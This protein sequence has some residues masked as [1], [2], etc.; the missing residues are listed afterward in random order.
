MDNL[1]WNEK[2]LS[3]GIKEMDA[4]HKKLISII[5]RLHAAKDKGEQHKV[6]S[7]ILEELEKYAEYH[8]KAEEDLLDETEFPELAPHIEHHK[9][10]V[11]KIKEYIER[12]DKGEIEITD[13]VL[14]FLWAWLIGHVRGVDRKY[15]EH[16]NKKGIR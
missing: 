11:Q 1:E 9:M 2:E 3:V 12:Y 14:G 15:T 7:H 8:F 13:E 4:H 6:L 10:Y 16:L 5:K